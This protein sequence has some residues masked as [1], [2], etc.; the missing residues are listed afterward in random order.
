M[1]GLRYLFAGSCN[2]MAVGSDMTDSSLIPVPASGSYRRPAG[3]Q[4][5]VNLVKK[6]VFVVE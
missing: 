2:D 5:G 6:Q 4:A 1:K 3:A